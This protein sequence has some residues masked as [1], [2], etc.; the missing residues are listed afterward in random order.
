MAKRNEL[1]NSEEI[2][3]EKEEI[4]VKCQKR[5]REGRIKDRIQGFTLPCG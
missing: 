2:L 5:M 4:R 1:G 3:K